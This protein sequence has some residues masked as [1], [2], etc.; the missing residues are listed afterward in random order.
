MMRVGVWM[1]VALVGLAGSPAA[2]S[3][4]ERDRKTLKGLRGLAVVVEDLAPE[5]ERHVP[6]STVQTDVELKLR[7]AGIT[8]L[9]R[10]DLVSTPGSPYLYVHINGLQSN[11]QP[12]FAYSTTVSLTQKVVL[13]RD[14][15]VGLLAETWSSSA[16]SLAGTVML[17]EG[18]RQ[19]I[20]EHVDRFINAY[21]SVNPKR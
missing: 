18:V 15:E 4:F 13:V 17:S 16:V 6:V 11:I 12:L 19:A 1:L 20:R 8:V 14:P 2:A 5:V 7:L 3:D 10:Q 21:L 9:S